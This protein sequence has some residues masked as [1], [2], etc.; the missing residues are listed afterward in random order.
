MW[1]VISWFFRIVAL[2]VWPDKDYYGV[3]WPQN[4]M[5]RQLARRV[6][7]GFFGGGCPG[8]VPQG[9]RIPC[10]DEVPRPL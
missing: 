6:P 8:G 9:F 2:G 10:F 3:P 7:N 1:D 4:S 5:R